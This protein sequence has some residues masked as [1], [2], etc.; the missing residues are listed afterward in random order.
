MVTYIDHTNTVVIRRVH[1]IYIIK[2]KVD[3]VQLN[4]LYILNQTFGSNAW[5]HTF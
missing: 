5:S 4:L 1:Y 2:C 3:N